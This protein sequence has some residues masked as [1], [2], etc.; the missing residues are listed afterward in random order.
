MLLNFFNSIE[1][2]VLILM[3]AL[4]GFLFGKLGWMKEEH[5]SFIVKVLLNVGVPSTCISNLFSRFDR[6]L[7]MSAGRYVLV[8]LITILAMILLS[9]LLAKAM[10]I[11]RERF[12]VFV[13][14]CSLSNSIFIGLPMNLILFGDASVQVVLF[15]YMANTIVFWTL[16]NAFIQHSGNADFKKLTVKD[17]IKKL[18]KAP[19]ITLIISIPLVAAGFKLPSIFTRF[20]TYFANIVTP[21]AMVHVGYLIYETGLSKIRIEKMHWAV[22]L[23]RFIVA[24]AIIFVIGKLFLLDALPLKVMTVEASMPVITQAVIL[25]SAVNADEKFTASGLSITT[26][27]SLIAV[28]LLMLM[29]SNLQ[30]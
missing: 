6:E 1:A 22:I 9:T 10:K 19:L 13:V 14:M 29:L 7:L 4:S 2:V 3:M 8:P 21:L 27:V 28:P 30:L 25:A 24:P 20:F 12:G 11:K 15:Y 23:M 26:I 18:L 17:R 5:K 16:G